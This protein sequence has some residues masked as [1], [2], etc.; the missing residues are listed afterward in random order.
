MFIDPI[1]RNGNRNPSLNISQIG[2][3]INGWPGTFR[4]STLPPFLEEPISRRRP[5]LL[6]PAEVRIIMFEFIDSG[7][8]R[9]ERGGGGAERGEGERGHAR[10]CRRRRTWR[11]QGVLYES[12][13]EVWYRRAP[14]AFSS[15][16][17]RRAMRDR[18]NHDCGAGGVTIA[19]QDAGP[20]S[21]NKSHKRVVLIVCRRSSNFRARRNFRNL[22]YVE[23]QNF[24]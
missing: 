10:G 15:A 23:T 18:P 16:G 9:W 2:P 14:L 20:G 4:I 6:S 19:N 17:S 5:R 12:V 24:S 1:A 8:P 22:E 11:Y 21:R 13:Y 3:R 7:A